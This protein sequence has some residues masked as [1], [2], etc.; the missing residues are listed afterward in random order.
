[1]TN[2]DIAYLRLL[3]DWH[4]RQA[5]CLLLTVPA[6]VFHTGARYVRL[7]ASVLVVLDRTFDDAEELREFSLR[8]LA[9]FANFGKPLADAE[10]H[11]AVP[12]CVLHP[13]EG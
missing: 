9:G 7:V 8:Y 3:A 13:L 11:A 6:N 5:R 12:L 10:I 2:D 4:D 1:M